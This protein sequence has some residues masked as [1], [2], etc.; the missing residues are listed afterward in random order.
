MSIDFLVRVINDAGDWGH[1]YMDMEE[2]KIDR[3]TGKDR[4]GQ[5][6]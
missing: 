1:K 2:E 3:L 6:E 5:I 4:H